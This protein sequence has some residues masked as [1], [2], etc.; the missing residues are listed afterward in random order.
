MRHKVK[1]KRIE[2]SFLFEKEITKVEIFMWFAAS[3]H[4]NEL[5][6]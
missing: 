1:Q 5:K 4:H 2:N 6:L 3:A